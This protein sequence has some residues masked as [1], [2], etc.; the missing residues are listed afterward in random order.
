MKE[1]KEYGETLAWPP[2]N[3]L[4]TWE[5]CSQRVDNAEYLEKEGMNRF[6][7]DDPDCVPNELHSFIYE[8][9][10]IDTYKSSWFL[11]RL[12]RL[13]SAVKENPSNF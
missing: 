4:P 9:D 7:T 1:L 10:D 2:L 8:Y 13:I 3:S 11:H 12:E 6:D 5:E